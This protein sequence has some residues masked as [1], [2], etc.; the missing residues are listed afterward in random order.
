M[1]HTSRGEKA[2]IEKAKKAAVSAKTP[3]DKLRAQCLARGANGIK[4]LG[5]A[6][7]I[8]DDDGNRKIEYREFVKGLRDYG[9]D[10]DKHEQQ[11]LFQEL[12]TDGSG[13]LDFDEFLIALRPAMS[14]NRVNLINQAFR[15]LDKSG[16]GI[17]TVEDLHGV[18]SVAKHPKFL[19]GEKTEDECLY[20]FL[21]NFDTIEQDGKITKDEF[22]N[23]YAGVSASI[24]S[25]AYFDLM[26]KNAWKLG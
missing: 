14:K 12:D 16:D 7:R 13:T 23:Y 10:L 6:F 8:M 22:N 5:R 17:V 19:N 26:M 1:A 24:D 15:K 11:E 3:L 4:G 21:K 20:D 25:D 9:V 2:L 18:Y